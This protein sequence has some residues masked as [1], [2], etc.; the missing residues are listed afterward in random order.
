MNHHRFNV[1]VAI[2]FALTFEVTNKNCLEKQRM[3]IDM[4]NRKH[5]L[6]S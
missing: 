3:L 6:I 2:T 5:F 4:K 1:I